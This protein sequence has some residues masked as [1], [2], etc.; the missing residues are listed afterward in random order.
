MM[1]TFFRY[2]VAGEIATEKG[3]SNFIVASFGKLSVGEGGWSNSKGRN[4]E[5]YYLLEKLDRSKLKRG[6]F[7]CLKE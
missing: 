3:P 2:S 6:S 5:Q 1:G 4:G 7:L